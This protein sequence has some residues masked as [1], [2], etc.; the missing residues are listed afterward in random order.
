MY[1]FTIPNKENNHDKSSLIFPQTEKASIIDQL[2]LSCPDDTPTKKDIMIIE[3][4]GD[5]PSLEMEELKKV[6]GYTSLLIKI[7]LH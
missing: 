5:D 3:E 4:V 6:T 1:E 2:A 7:M